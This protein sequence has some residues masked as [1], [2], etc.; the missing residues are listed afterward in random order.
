MR[1]TLN[2]RFS[3]LI[4]FLLFMPMMIHAF[5][6]EGITIRG[7]VTDEALKE[8][9]PGANVTV[10]GTTI[11]TIT[12][13]D[14]TYSIVVPS[15]KSV[16]VF[17][18]MGYVT[19]EIT[20]G[21]KRTID[22]SLKE[23]ANVLGEVEVVA[24]AYGNQ[25][26]NLLTSAVSSISNKE[27]I[28]S[29]V[30]SVTN[31]LAGAMPGVS[32]VQ[33]SG[34]PGK[35]AAAIYVRGSGSLNDSQSKPLILVDGV[36]REFSQID[37]NEIESISIL[38]DASSTAVFGVRGANGVVLVT[39]RR[40]KSGKPQINVSTSLGLQQPISLVEQTGSYEF[41]RFWNIKQQ[42]DGVADKKRYF[43]PE[44]VEAYRT[45]SDP[46]MY[47]SMDWK[48]YIF[49]DV[50]LQSKNNINISGGS[51]DV[52]YFISIGYLYQNGLLKD[53]P[54]QKYNNNYRYD[55]YN[56]RANI[57]AKLTKT[58]TMKLGIGGNLGKTQ[59]PRSVVS[60][61]GQDQNP[62]VIAQIWSHPFAGPGFID[63][64]RT[65]VPKDL[66]P[67]GEVLRDGMF[68]FYGKGYTQ[69][70]RTNLNLDLDIT[71]KMDFLTK[72]LSVSVK[73]AYDNAFKLF[74]K[75]PGGDVE[76]Q[77]VYYKSYFDS[78]GNMP[79]TDPDYDKSLI[80]LPSGSDT[81]LGY[82]EERGRD[83]NWYIEGRVNY[84]RAFGNH[85][86]SGLLLYNQSR[87]YYPDAYTY[88][89]RSYIGFVGRA[90]YSY[91]SKYLFDVNV[92]YNGSENFA[93]GKN[94]F[95]IFPAF[96]AGWVASAEKFMANQHVVD[97]LKL[98]LSWGRVGSD[99]GIDSRFMYMPAVWQQSGG[100]SFGV[101]TPENAPAFGITKI[102]NPHVTWETADKQNY[103]I[104][105]KFLDNRLSLN[106]DYFMER[107][108]G[109]LITP[110]STPAIIATSLPN[111]NIGKVNNHGYEVALG[112]NDAIGKDF[113]YYMNANVSFARNKIIYRDEVPKQFDYMN[114]TGGST[115]R[116]TNVYKYI[117]L[118]QQDDFI[119]DAEGGLT[120]KPELPQP[121]QKVYP[122]DA[123]YAD[124]NGDNIV[125]GK[126]RCVAGY[127]TRPEYTFG[128]NMGCNWKGF[129]FSMQWAGAA[130]VSRM[131]DIEYRIPF[132]NAGKRG[133]LTY[134][135]NDCWTPE[136]QLG[137]VYPRPAEESE[138]WNSEP[139]TLWLQD[140]SYLRLKSLNVGYTISGNRL[141]K[142]VGVKS[143]GITFSGYNLLTFSPLKY[144]DPES[145]PDRLGDYPLIKLYSFGLNL[146]F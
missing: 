2:L 139:S 22:V 41:A 90:T 3:F 84:E 104:D 88:I 128:L 55:R 78:N 126:D 49:H 105:V 29:P 144:I 99:K 120:L 87:D 60:D 68:V 28:K 6:P 74:K 56:Y 125:D 109:I 14:G 71:Q 54:G 130:N 83:Q 137:A 92:G 132:T 79:A 45:G 37:P 61:T 145:N 31:V 131:Y 46:I 52:K 119:K 4:A 91:L 143:L 82:A 44:Q 21:D 7:R 146:N 16:L 134:F 138:S 64:V 57:D 13:F 129:S 59:E 20:V 25:D 47:P 112:W 10:K 27:L 117:R 11:G 34:Q 24:I 85:K 123:M 65:L 97:Y 42:L 33:T 80:Y 116:Q 1:N 70:Y 110:E 93:P 53:L 133:L 15:K 17:S 108:T 69:N 18:F 103:G 111:S 72:G 100:Y 118:Y 8:A 76:S 38:K 51:E 12:G 9:V 5:P 101:N 67:L 48:K 66:V 89:P 23:D 32:S 36:E 35:D 140:A 26:K 135:Y 81:P 40:G 62:W 106:F 86:V 58:T 39:T 113:N 30:A 43:T 136:N 98:R 19:Q 73:G 121:Y 77:T 142:K 124:L 63:G 141:L 115:G 95:G 96:S 122:G 114:V 107:R 127:A 94:R 102:G 50:Y 75:R